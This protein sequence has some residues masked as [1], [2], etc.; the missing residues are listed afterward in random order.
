MLP[1]IYVFSVYDAYV[2]TAELKN[3]ADGQFDVFNSI[4][5]DRNSTEGRKKDR[6]KVFRKHGTDG[7]EL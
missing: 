7:R 5:Q 3:I 6:T 2:N 1:S 4:T